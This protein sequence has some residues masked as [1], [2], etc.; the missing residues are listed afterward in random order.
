ML[1]IKD[2]TIKT[3]KGRELISHLNLTVNR[4]DKL[5]IIGEEGNGKSTLLQCIADRKMVESYCLVSGS[6]QKDHIKIGYLPQFLEKIW[7]QQTIE[8]YFFKENGQSEINYEK[9]EEY[10]QLEQ[11][12]KDIGINESYLQENRKM[13]S[14]SGGEIIKIEIAKL[15]FWQSDFLLLDEPTN[16]LDIETL[17][18]LEN[19]IN[20]EEK[21]IMYISH[22]ETLLENTA[23]AI[24]HL[25][26]LE[27]KTKAK[28]TY[29]HIGYREYTIKRQNWIDKQ[30]RMAEND[31]RR[32]QKQQEKWNR[33]FQSVEYKQETITRQNP[34]KARLLAK[35][36]KQVKA[37]ERRFEKEELM[38]RVFPEEA[39]FGKFHNGEPIHSSKI[40]ID[41]QL[42]NHNS[43][44]KKEKIA[45]RVMG[46]EKWCL[47]GKN[48]A[49]K[50]TLLKE[51]YHLLKDRQDIRVSYMPQ[52]Y[53]EVLPADMTPIIFLNQEGI[54]EKETMARTYLGCMKFT[55]EEMNLPIGML[56]GGQKAKIFLIKMMME[57][58]HVLLLDEPTRNLSPLSNPVI[59]KLLK[60]F[61]GAIISVSHDRKY[62]KEVC[63]H[64]YEM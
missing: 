15:L 39:I 46:K 35:K 44:I 30:N 24:L 12:L 60:E 4:G 50:T 38:Q 16:D 57:P 10:Y 55:Q 14:F 54:R 22:D 29:E 61:N 41:L 1:E 18:W 51:I 33:I 13:E 2:L 58:N 43:R 11:I 62:I 23:N 19:Y 52:N 59:R 9:Y 31:A 3:I 8:E 32:H 27:N 17:E 26:Q 25:E 53:E 40:I 42:E 64:I 63:D 34:S 45:L 20:T 48:G 6:I 47:L 36:M 21:P 37:M 56:S 7:K 5:A 49:G 28:W